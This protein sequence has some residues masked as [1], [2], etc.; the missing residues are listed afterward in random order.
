[1]PCFHD[2][3]DFVGVCSKVSTALPVKS[4]FPLEF[5]RAFPSESISRLWSKTVAEGG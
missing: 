3:I 5:T 1:L 4:G 2:E